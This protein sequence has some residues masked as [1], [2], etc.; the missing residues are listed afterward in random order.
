MN[1]NPVER[2]ETGFTLAEVILYVALFALIIGAIVGL[3]SLSSLQRV[4]SQVIAEI[5]YHGENALTL[6]SQTIRNS[7]SIN[8]PSLG[9]S[10]NQLNLTTQ[11]PSTSPTIFDS[12]LDGSTNRLRLSEGSPA[13]L[14]Y[15]TSH[16]VQLSGLTFT[17]AGASG[18]KGSIAVT[19]VLTY[20]SSSTAAEYT[21]SKTFF[22]AATLQ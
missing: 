14:N 9:N 6:I 17:N 3:A 5:N 22:G 20:N 16:N 19:F 12:Y 4:Q 15:L 13:T 11:D 2:R 1:L 18:T 8:S 10:G 7:S 21:Y